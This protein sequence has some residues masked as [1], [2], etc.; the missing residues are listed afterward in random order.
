MINC[1][2]CMKMAMRMLRILILRGT[3]S[4]TRLID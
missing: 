2:K 3:A 4:K 1:G